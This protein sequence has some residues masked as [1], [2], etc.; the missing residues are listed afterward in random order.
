M[1]R[2]A[3]RFLACPACRHELALEVHRFEQTEVVDGNLRCTRCQSEYPIVRGIPRFVPSETY[4]ASFGLEWNLFSTVQLDSINGTQQSDQMLHA[5]TGWTADDYAGRLVLD[6][7]VGSGRFAEIAAA[8]GAEVVGVD[9]SSAVEAAYRNVGRLDNVHVIQADIFALPFRAGTFDLAYSIGVLHH[10]PDPAGAF[11][12]VAATVKPRG[13]FGV[14]LY[15]RYSIGRYS[16]DA[17]RVVTTRLPFRVTLALCT[18]A[19][20]YYYL[21]RL[22]FL[23][24]LLQ[25]AC[26]ISMHPD[27]RSRW[28]DTFDW[29]SPAYQW[30]LVYPEVS[31]WFRENGF[32]DV[33]VFDGPIRMCG[34]KTERVTANARPDLAAVARAR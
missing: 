13:G 2:S 34:V 24:K 23:G 19:V 3:M 5:S 14:Y 25:L 29:Y 18:L 15:D 28:L 20:P 12:R 7:G 10:T 16:S 32:N 22:P 1:K 6:A 21:C 26:P 4:A 27:W 8:Y 31:R 17:I 33:D 11:S 9:L 30:K